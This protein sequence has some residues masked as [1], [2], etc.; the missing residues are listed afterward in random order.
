MKMKN[1]SPGSKKKIRLW[2]SDLA[3]SCIFKN[4]WIT[5][6]GLLFA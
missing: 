2:D 6:A 3:L 4:W 5:A 1:E